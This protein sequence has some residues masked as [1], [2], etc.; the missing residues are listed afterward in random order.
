MLK[1]SSIESNLCVISLV[2]NWRFQIKFKFKSK[3]SASNVFQSGFLS[4]EMLKLKYY[5]NLSKTKFVHNEKFPKNLCS[6]NWCSVQFDISGNG[7]IIYF[8]QNIQF[9]FV[10]IIISRFENA[11]L[12][13]YLTFM[14]NVCEYVKLYTS[15][16]LLMTFLCHQKHPSSKHSMI[17][18]SNIW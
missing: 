5:S 3:T 17:I 9:F 10:Q 4:H 15:K 16:Y 7:I 6:N 1:I 12:I 18:C 2:D 13:K 11:K 14:V 8:N